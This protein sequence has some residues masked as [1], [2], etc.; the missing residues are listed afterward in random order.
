[1]DNHDLV[2]ANLP[3]DAEKQDQVVE[4]T[5]AAIGP[6]TNQPHAVTATTTIATATT[7]THNDLQK[8]NWLLKAELGNLIAA[9]KQARQDHG[10]TQNHLRQ[11]ISQMQEGHAVERSNL[12]SQIEHARTQ[13]TLQLHPKEK[14]DFEA[15]ID[16]LE[17]QH[18]LERN[19]LEK[20][21]KDLQSCST[22]AGM[23]TNL[24]L[25]FTLLHYCFGGRSRTVRL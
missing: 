17:K 5:T 19:E 8:E 12:L 24:S 16:D 7:T 20:K 6:E 22:T 23:S 9:S 15:Q 10:H 21:V 11:T 4:E 25:L 18:G 1:M 2:N 3:S 13:L 14:R